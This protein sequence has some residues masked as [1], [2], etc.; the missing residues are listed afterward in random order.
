MLYRPGAQDGNRY[1]PPPSGNT[2]LVGAAL[3]SLLLLLM[4]AVAA[5]FDIG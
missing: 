3:W 4:T 5:Q 1:G 2:T